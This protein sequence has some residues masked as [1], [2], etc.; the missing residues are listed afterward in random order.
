MSD[1]A[2]VNLINLLILGCASGQVLLPEHLRQSHLTQWEIGMSGA[3]FSCAAILTRFKLGGWMARYG[4]LPFLRLGALLVAFGHSAYAVVEPS[5]AT[6]CALRAL[7]GCALASYFTAVLARVMDLAPAGRVGRVTGL[8]GISGLWA[9]AAGP[10]LLE[11]AARHWN[12]P[13]AFACGATLG[14][15]GFSL[16][17]RFRSES[18]VQAASLP[19]WSIARSTAMRSTVLSSW[20]FGMALGVFNT[21]VVVYALSCGMPWVGPMFVLYT[22]ASIGARLK[23]GHLADVWEP[24]RLIV[25]AFALLGLACLGL[26]LLRLFPV[27]GL[28]LAA[29]S[30]VGVAHGMIYPAISQLAL[31]RA[32]SG[33][34]GAT[35]VFT[36]AMDLGMLVGCAAGGWI[37]HL[38]G[39][40]V[41]FQAAGLLLLAGALRIWALERKL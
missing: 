16:C 20:L 41:A 7:E 34:N 9:G 12:Y 28:F 23:L 11:Q 1:F 32:G 39:H 19:F 31:R 15:I 5:A 26:S 6:I 8:F 2:W 22:A 37:S 18:E 40:A 29:G 10:A 21:F 24:V 33:S 17:W 25:P 14:W 35:A 38:L 27:Y 3:A 13:T 4:Q 30:G 36:A